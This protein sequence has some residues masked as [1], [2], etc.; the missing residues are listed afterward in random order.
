[1]SALAQLQ[2]LA[3]ILAILAL[4]W[5]LSESRADLRNRALARV[6]LVGLVTL[7]VLALVLL[8]WPVAR[9]VF[10]WLNQ[11]VI[12]IDKATLAGTSFV[13]GFVGGGPA[14]FDPQKPQFLGVLAF[15]YLPI[16]LVIS[17][18][19]AILF[20]WRVLPLIVRGFS[21][22]LEKTLGI[23]GA[24]GLGSA[25]NVFVGMVE[26]PI[27]IRPYVAAM[28]RGELFA[29]MSVGMATVAGTVI[30]LYATILG[31]TVPGALGHILSASI[32]NVPSAL[33][34]S[35]LL[36]PFVHQVQTEGAMEPERDGG[37]TIEAL[38]RGTA[39]GVMLLIHVVAMLLVLVALV[40]L[41][42]QLI[43]LLPDVGGKPL[44]LERILGWVLSPLAW[45]IGIPWAE[46][47]TAG[48]LLG[49]KI[50]LNELKA[51]L[52]LGALPAGTLSPRSTLIMVYA[53]CG[54]ANLGSLGIMV[55]GIS[56]LV[57]ERRREIAGLGAKAVLGG[58]L[59]TCLTA[60]VVGLF[61]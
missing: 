9:S 4:C 23:R 51:Y 25:A 52:D 1:M 37:N 28:R 38:I 57:P 22:V 12:A 21:W 11:V 27:L 5:G 24:L 13:F 2:G 19:S 59:A 53:M 26:S 7:V 16:I 56:A 17:A 50:I 45:A 6:V 49:T 46:A 55:G 39:D 42:N 15:R 58:L 41:A 30:V 48:Q 20:H 34:V 3:G 44:S 31:N 36:V 40:A 32:L 61:L 14:P 60:S 18:V 8:K 35:A 33:I 43:G 29:L 54:F 10:L 47:E